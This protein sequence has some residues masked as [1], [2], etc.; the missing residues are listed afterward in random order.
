MQKKSQITEDEK[1][2]SSKH[3]DLRSKYC[4]SI[5]CPHLSPLFRVFREQ[6][7]TR[8]KWTISPNG[9]RSPSVSLPY[10]CSFQG[11]PA[12]QPVLPFLLH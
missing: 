9:L 6:D 1:H 3:R 4:I 11:V 7:G 12:L 10:P 8:L 5:L 2:K